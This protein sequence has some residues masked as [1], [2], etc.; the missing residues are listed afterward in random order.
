MF[1]DDAQFIMLYDGDC[2]FCRYW[3]RRWQKKIGDSIT[4]EAYQTAHKRYEQVSEAMCREA[5]QLV[6]PKGFVFSGAHAVFRAFDV[7]GKFRFLHWMYDHVPLFGRSC[8]FGY[9]WVAHH[10]FLLSRFFGGSVKKCNGAS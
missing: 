7:A 4:F 5:V 9:Q 10:R 2:G 3:V 6:T 8:E 1:D